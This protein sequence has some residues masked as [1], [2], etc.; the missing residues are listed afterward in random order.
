MYHRDTT[1]VSGQPFGALIGRIGAGGEIFFIG[2]KASKSNLPPGRLQMAVNDNAHWQ[3]NLG[4]YS[5]TLTATDA[6]DLGEPQ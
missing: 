4:A 1:L 2:R 3:N 5:V 6:Y